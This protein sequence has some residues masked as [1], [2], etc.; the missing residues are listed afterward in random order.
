MVRRIELLERRGWVDE[1]KA[2]DAVLGNAAPTRIALSTLLKEYEVERRTHLA[3][4][5]PDQLRRWRNG[6]KRA[7]ANFKAVLGRNAYLEDLTRTDAL[8]FRE[9]W[10]DRVIGEG[11]QVATANKDIGNLNRMIRTLNRARR[12]GLEPIFAELRIE[13]E[14]YGSRA[15][16]TVEFIQTKILADGALDGLNPE[17]RRVIYVCAEIGLRPVEVVNLTKG[18]IRLDCD[19]PHVV[20]QAEGRVLKTDHSE[21]HIPLVGVALEAMKMQP[22]GFPTYFD[23]SPALSATVNKFLSAHD[24]RPTD[25]HS[26]YSLRHTFE[27]RLT[28]VEAPEKI[29]CY[30]MGHKYSRPKYGSPPSLEQL[31]G[32]LDKIAFRAPTSI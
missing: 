22:E 6:K 11:V 25:R 7:I 17:A 27:D 30:A 13:G 31:K 21:R 32:W 18:A 10:Q 19:V 20:V 28:A 15:P 12:L 16:Y 3:K 23:G 9:W 2:A 4:F 8:D 14:K 29:L 5:S 26:L 1:P 24:L